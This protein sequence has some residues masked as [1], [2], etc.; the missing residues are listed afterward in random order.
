MGRGFF[1]GVFWASVVSIVG[2][3][4]MSQLGDVISGNSKP[5]SPV[6]EQVPDNA[7]VVAEA[8]PQT[9]VEQAAAPV[10]APQSTDADAPGEPKPDT[11]QT[12]P[13]QT[14][15]SV[16]TLK[17]PVAGNAPQAPAVSASKTAVTPTTPLAGQPQADKAPGVGAA[18][19]LPKVSEPTK[20][21]TTSPADQSDAEASVA[22]STVVAAGVVAAGEPSAPKAPVR[23]SVPS[24]D[25]SN[26]QVVPTPTQESADEPKAPSADV[27]V[28]AAAPQIEAVPT[29][30]PVP[31]PVAT[32][33]APLPTPTP[34][35]AP[36]LVAK[37]VV[38]PEAAPKDTPA[39]GQ[40][41]SGAGGTTGSLLKPVTGIGNRAPNVQTN[42]LPSI[43]GS[44]P[45][46]EVTAEPAEPGG[47]PELTD[48]PAIEQFAAVFENPEARPLMA[49]LLLTDTGDTGAATDAALPFPV[50]Y[51]V[52]ASKSNAPDLMRRYRDA[53][54]E[55]VVLAPLP[56][57]AA[58]VDVEVAFLSYLSAVPE[59][60]AVMDVPEGDFQAGRTLASQVADALAASG[61]GM[62]TYKRGLNSAIQVAE[63][64]G[65]PAALVFSDIDGIGQNG[66]AIKRFIDRAAFRAGQQGGVILVGR[67]RPETIKALLE[68]GLGNRANTVALAPVSVVLKA[69]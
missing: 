2:L 59:A 17:E 20:S 54:N 43:G 37:P 16:V 29:P 36:E 31:A 39:E 28:S 13:P 4:L 46:A 42:R 21:L 32:P 51:V 49:I 7:P 55:V 26:P 66:A 53:G 12:P 1:S 22:S 9:S 8:A 50:S 68:W 44:A 48:A 47:A 64:E 38:V 61:H 58:P 3:G 34:A 69:Q 10:V 15:I 11:D 25:F 56:E 41:N 30:A 23:E 62:I 52:D 27:V 67:N 6:A 65:V 33:A 45:E 24:V 18:P 40:P 19:T 14:A 63:R 57:G 35:P 60:V 5:G